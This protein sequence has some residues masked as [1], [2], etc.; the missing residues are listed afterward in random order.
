MTRGSREN[1]GKPITKVNGYV[2]KYIIYTVTQSI[3]KEREKWDETEIIK[4][5]QMMGEVFSL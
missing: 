5:G 1:E 2:Y 3:E 4:K